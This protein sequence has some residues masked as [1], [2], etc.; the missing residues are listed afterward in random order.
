MKIILY[1]LLLCPALGF[2][3]TTVTEIFSSLD[4]NYTK[5]TQLDNGD[6]LTFSHGITEDQPNSINTMS[7]IEGSTAVVSECTT[8]DWPEDHLFPIAIHFFNNDEGVVAMA[9]DFGGYGPSGIFKT[10]DGG[11]TYERT[12]SAAV[13]GGLDGVTDMAFFDDQI[14]IALVS[15]FFES[16][17]IKTTDGGSTWTEIQSFPT[18]HLAS[19]ALTDEGNFIVSANIYDSN[20]ETESWQIIK[21]EDYGTSYEEIFSTPDITKNIDNIQFLNENVGFVS[22]YTWDTTEYDYIYKTTDGGITWEE[23]PNFE[24]VMDEHMHIRKIE[25]YN[26]MEGFVLASDY[27]TPQ[28]CYRSGAL[29]KTIDG[30]QNWT[31]EFKIAPS[32]HNFWDMALDNSTGEGYIV[33]GDISNGHGTIHH[34]EFDSGTSI[35]DLKFQ[36]H[37]AIYPNPSSGQV[38]IQLSNA[39]SGKLQVFNPQGQIVLS[40]NIENSKMVDLQLPGGLFHYRFTTESSYDIGTIV[41]TK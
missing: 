18:Q 41:I 10:Y 33:G 32:D 13:D 21:F 37:I 39:R 36:D 6:F 16:I 7:I 38:S 12:Y 1:I 14:G 17:V 15:F 5:I 3:Q 24:P 31:V 28:A 20:Y 22:L 8:V 40:Q 26:E 27:C 11:Q 23:I 30:G 35:I 19:L 2:S 9:Q 34:V 4:Q 29:L 25:F